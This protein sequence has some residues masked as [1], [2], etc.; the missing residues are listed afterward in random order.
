M[1]PLCR[2]PPDDWNGSSVAQVRA[3]QAAWKH[4]T[5]GPF[6]SQADGAG[7]SET[8]LRRTAQSLGGAYLCNVPSGMSLLVLSGHGCLGVT[9]P[10][11]C[12]PR[13]AHEHGRTS[14]R[15][16]F[17]GEDASHLLS[18]KGSVQLGAAR[19]PHNVARSMPN[20]LTSEWTFL[21]FGQRVLL[22]LTSPGSDCPTVW[23]SGFDLFFRFP[24]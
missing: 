22:S 7:G 24:V 11:K 14:H 6:A 5:E 13:P 17:G 18:A 8:S 2:D 21:P 1:G 15:C 4:R 19:C 12:S 3:A 20:L 16:P 9:N 23:F 10:V